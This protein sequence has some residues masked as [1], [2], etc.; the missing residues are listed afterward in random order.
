MSN[1]FDAA[2][3]FVD[4]WWFVLNKKFRNMWL[5]DYKEANCFGKSFAMTE[6]V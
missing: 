4:F 3:Y 5:R 6:K 1:G 2:V